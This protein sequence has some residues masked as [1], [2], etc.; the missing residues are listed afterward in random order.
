MQSN[1]LQYK[2]RCTPLHHF[3]FKVVLHTFAPL[4]HRCIRPASLQYVHFIHLI[5]DA[6][7]TIHVSLPL[8]LRS[9]PH[10]WKLR[11]YLYTVGD[12]RCIVHRVSCKVAFGKRHWRSIQFEKSCMWR[13]KEDDCQQSWPRTGKAPKWCGVRGSILLY[14]FFAASLHPCTLRLPPLR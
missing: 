9:P 1:A 3:I 5:H 14:T 6:R 13:C 10:V 7:C 8:P 11:Q 12:R 4:H 2:I